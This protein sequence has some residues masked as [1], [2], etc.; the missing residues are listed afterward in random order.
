MPDDVWEEAEHVFGDECLAKV[1]MA[2]VTINAWNRI[3]VSTRMAQ[4]APQP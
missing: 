1:L 3:A 2:I 4:E